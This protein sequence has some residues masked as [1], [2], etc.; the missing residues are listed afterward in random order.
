MSQQVGGVLVLQSDGKPL[1]GFR[2]KVTDGKIAEAEH[3]FAA[4][5]NANLQTVRAPSRWKCPTS[6]ADSRGL[7]SSAR[8]IASS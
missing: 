2:L 1:V 5:G 3:V 7:R 6:G 8:E 4:G